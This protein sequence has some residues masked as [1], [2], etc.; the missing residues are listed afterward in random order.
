M[1][2]KMVSSLYH[3]KKYLTFAIMLIITSGR[4]KIKY[5]CRS[6]PKYKV[7]PVWKVID[8]VFWDQ[9]EVILFVYNQWS[10]DQ[11][12]HT[13]AHCQNSE[14]WRCVMCFSDITMKGS[15]MTR[16]DVWTTSSLLLTVLT[17]HNLK[18]NCFTS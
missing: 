13:W 3:S 17:W 16:Q 6:C 12:S 5:C 14:L 10:H 2:E 11:F 18:F 8:I 4:P 7:H 9:K 1:L 15:L